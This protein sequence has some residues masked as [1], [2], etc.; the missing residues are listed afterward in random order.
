MTKGR[1][2]KVA[3]LIEEYDLEG[4]GGELEARWT[5]DDPD[6]RMSLRDLA[7]YFNRQLVQQTVGD[8]DMQTLDGEVANV[9]RLLTDDG[10]S[11]GDRTRA[12]RRLEREGVDVDTLMN[13]F[14]SYQ[15]IRTYL[16]EYRD[17]EYETEGT[18]LESVMATVQQL[19]G[20]TTT[21]VESKLEQ[22]RNQALTLGRFRVLVTV[23]VAC[24]DC[25][26]QYDVADLL[27]RGGCDCEQ[28]S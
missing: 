4:F 27:E 15:A 16:R 6:E 28:D 13:D 22:L 8:T 12:R 1:S 25:G 11:G 17:A 3:R 2:S 18:R 5:A 14:V 24:E 23:R 20:R 21:V 10:V 19:R 7:D 26:A 9:Y